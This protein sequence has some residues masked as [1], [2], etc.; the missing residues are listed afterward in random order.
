MIEAV[1]WVRGE[2]GFTLL[3]LLV[4][5]L[6]AAVLTEVA[7][8]TLAGTAK[9]AAR[10]V[11]QANVNTLQIA[12]EFYHLENGSYPPTGTVDDFHRLPDIYPA[13]FTSSERVTAPSSWSGLFTEALRESRPDGGNI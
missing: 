4:V 13:G 3:E 8:L 9:I 2:K 5:L 7:A 1:P 6:I 10:T 12:A 11:C